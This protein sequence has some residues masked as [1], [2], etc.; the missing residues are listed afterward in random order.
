MPGDLTT[1]AISAVLS[2]RLLFVIIRR[3]SFHR[4]EL[5]LKVEL[6]EVQCMAPGW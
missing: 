2:E 4:S 3:G 5:M 1:V 6:V